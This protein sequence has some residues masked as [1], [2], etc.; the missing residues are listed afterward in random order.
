MRAI[1]PAGATILLDRDTELAMVEYAA[2]EKHYSLTIVQNGCQPAP[3]LFVDRFKGETFPGT[4]D[5]C[6]GHYVPIAAATA[7]GLSGT[8]WTLYRRQPS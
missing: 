7:S 4:I 3:F 2:A 1:A 6:G 8:H 5:R